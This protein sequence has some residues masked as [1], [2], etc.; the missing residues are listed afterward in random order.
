MTALQMDPKSLIEVI[1]LSKH[2]LNEEGRLLLLT[3][4]DYDQINPSHL[5]LFCHFY[6]RYGLPTVELV[7]WLRERIGSRSAIEIGAGSGDL[8]YYLGIPMTDSRCQ[9]LPEIKAAYAQMGI[10]GQ[11]VINYAKDVEKL[12]ALEAVDKY[13]PEVVIAS[14]VTHWSDKDDG[15]FV[16]GVKESKLLDNVQEY[17][18]I[19]AK[20]IHDKKPIMKVTHQTHDLS[21]VKSRRQDN[22]VFVWSRR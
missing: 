11:P 20:S 13:K 16:C 4:A 7:E 10:A 19:G 9:E 15:G 8:G 6:A 3:A 17:I 22:A 2:L 5:R 21:F 12:E 14:W 18:L 1:E